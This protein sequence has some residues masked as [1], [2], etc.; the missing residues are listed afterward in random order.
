MRFDAVVVEER[1]VGVLLRRQR[2]D[3]SAEG[4]AVQAGARALRALRPV[5]IF[6]GA[7]GLGMAV[8]AIALLTDR[9]RLLRWA[10]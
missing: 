4:D 8:L 9:P 5:S 2:V 1:G 3:F 7:L 10:V 6:V